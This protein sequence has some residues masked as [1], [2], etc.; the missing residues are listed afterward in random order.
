[1]ENPPELQLMQ[2]L[3]F[4][5]AGI[6]AGVLYDICMALRRCFGRKA[7]ETA[8]VMIMKS[9]YYLCEV[10]EN[11][12]D[13]D[14]DEYEAEYGYNVIWSNLDEAVDMNRKVTDLEKCP[15]VVRD[16][17]VMEYLMENE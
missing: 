6:A 2:A 10:D 13:R 16:T 12:A 3:V 5:S 11:T 8:D 15:W 7:G 17:K 4:L 1:M 14:L 9:Y